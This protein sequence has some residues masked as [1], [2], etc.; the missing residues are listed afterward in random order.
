METRSLVSIIVGVIFQSIVLLVGHDHRVEVVKFI[1]EA[2][3]AEVE[4]VTFDGVA[5]VVEFYVDFVVRKNAHAVDLVYVY[6]FKEQGET[7]YS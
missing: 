5:S 6:G 1:D 7:S 2:D 3:F 4:H